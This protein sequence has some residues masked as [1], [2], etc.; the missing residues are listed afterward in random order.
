V[1]EARGVWLFGTICPTATHPGLRPP[2]SRGEEQPMS[3]NDITLRRL[4]RVIV[5]NALGVKQS[6]ISA[7][8]PLW[9]PDALKML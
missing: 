5:N 2:L 7:H 9:V 6:C 1:R 4:N 3:L 8:V